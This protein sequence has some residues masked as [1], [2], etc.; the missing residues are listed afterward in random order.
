M[1][2][3]R[4]L[5]VEDDHIIGMD[6]DRIVSEFGYEVTGIATSGQEALMMTEQQEP[7]LALMDIRLGS[8]LDGMAVAEQLRAKWSIPVIFVTA[9]A[10]L[11]TVRQTS[12][13]G[14][15]G[16]LTKPI[17]PEELRAAISIALHQHHDFYELLQSNVWLSSLLGS[18]TESVLAVDQNGKV[19]YLNPQAESITGWF[20]GDALGKPVDEVLRLFSPEGLALPETRVKMAAITQNGMAREKFLLRRRAG[21]NVPVEETVAVVWSKGRC[22]G[23]VS[24]FRDMSEA[25]KLE[26]AQKWQTLGV[27]AG[28]V[29]HDFNNLLTI[30]IGN[31]QLAMDSLPAKSK[32]T[33]FLSEAV[34]AGGRAGE[35]AEKLLAYAGKSV[36]HRRDLNI[37]KMVQGM[38][39][40]L[41]EVVPENVALTFDVAGDLPSINGDIGQLQQVLINLTLNAVEAIGEDRGSIFISAVLADRSQGVFLR[42]RDT[43]SGMDSKTRAKIFDPFFSTKFLGRGLGLSVVQG[44]VRSHGGTIDV[45]TRPGRGSVFTIFLPATNAGVAGTPSEVEL[46]AGDGSTILVVDDSDSVAK[47][48]QTTLERLGYKVVL[49][50]N[51][52]TALS[53]LESNDHSVDL[54][55]LDLFMPGLSGA[56]TADLISQRYP[57]LPV[58]F[59]SGYDESVAKEEVPEGLRN[60]F[61]QKPFTP[62]QLVREIRVSLEGKFGA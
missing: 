15:F 12:A 58:R 18:I 60:G 38:S 44:V 22:V 57:A 35:L 28:G 6:L 9:H 8:G 3:G 7:D 36:F 45:D 2:G 53:I 11:E 30:V 26:E 23:A 41:A 29:A 16:H 47:F 1:S 37:N 54:V 17:R 10:N 55:L 19:I 42:V 14:A 56:E 51:G 52:S 32:E 62:D 33:A 25:L 31:I 59:M 39:D 46:K 34:K 5:I 4:I 27:L 50:D 24:V 48:T 61:L 21:Q 43:G 13:L 49:A 40:L 20:A